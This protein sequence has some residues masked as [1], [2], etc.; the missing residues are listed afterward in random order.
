MILDEDRILD[1]GFEPQID[2]VITHH[3][4]A[5]YQQPENT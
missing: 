4:E 5:Q 3:H 2:Q 1:M